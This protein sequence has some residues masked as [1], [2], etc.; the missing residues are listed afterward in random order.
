MQTRRQSLLENNPSPNSQELADYAVS[1]H[2]VRPT[3]TK[4]LQWVRTEILPA[5][6]IMQNS[7][8]QVELYKQFIFPFFSLWKNEEGRV[9]KQYWYIRLSTS[10]FEV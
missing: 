8:Y 1:L 3:A 10:P 6:V 2:A 4:E 9:G 5:E 7:I